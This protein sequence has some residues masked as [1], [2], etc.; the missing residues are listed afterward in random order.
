MHPWIHET[1]IASGMTANY[2]MT[3]FWQGGKYAD[4]QNRRWS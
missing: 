3:Q 4:I 2:D 1:E